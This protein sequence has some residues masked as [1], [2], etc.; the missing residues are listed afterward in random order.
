[1]PEDVLKTPLGNMLMSQISSGFGRRGNGSILGLQD[2]GSSPQSLDTQNSNVAASQPYKTKKGVNQISN[3]TAL[4]QAL[5]QAKDSCAII[6]FTSATC[7]P[8]KVLYPLYDELA[9]EYH[10]Q[11]TFIKIDLAQP[12][13]AQIG[14]TYSVRATPTII[15]FLRGTEEN[16]WTGTDGARLR[17]NVQLLAQM[18]HPLHAHDKLNLPTLQN[19]HAAPVL[20]QKIPPMQKLMDKMGP[21]LSSEPRVQDLRA[22]IEKRARVGS[23]DAILPDMTSISGL[24]EDAINQL[25]PDTLFT[26]VELL[27]CAL[28][29]PRV[30]AYFAEEKDVRTA[31]HI[32]TFVN[33]LQGCPYSL[34]L[35]TLHMACNLFST[36]LFNHAVFQ[37]T[38]LRSAMTELTS[39][40]FLDDDHSNTRVAASCLLYNIA[41]AD[42]NAR[43]K[44]GK[45]GLSSD[46][47]IELAA[48][49]LEAITQEESSVEALQGMLT[50]L[51]H[52]LYRT[53]ADSELADLMRG[54]DAENIILG[55]KSRFP[56]EKLIGEVGSE[57]IGKGLRRS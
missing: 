4:S 51:G 52:L 39:S 10:D 22:F 47:K 56:Q 20:F 29:D 34:R 45:S 1:M 19:Q 44:D 38:T 15:T 30:S 48:A 13:A 28:V 11:I 49:V 55:K 14:G 35:V 40:S 2:E 23:Q 27:R 43:I 46:D 3:S 41:L 42:R 8:C 37:N 54:M 36:P 50:A 32:F 5:D 21:V 57:L 6:F 7:A 24:M 17:G 31:L 18:A 12:E 25:A 9:S 26:T 53:E 33:G 16:R